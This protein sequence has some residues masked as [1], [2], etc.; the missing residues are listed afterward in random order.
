M[1]YEYRPGAAK[2]FPPWVVSA[3]G[4]AV[5]H[6]YQGTEREFRMSLVGRDGIDSLPMLLVT[7]EDEDEI[8]DD[9]EAIMR[10]SADAYA[11]FTAHNE[12][13]AADED[14]LVPD[15]LQLGG[16]A[17]SLTCEGVPFG[18]V[19]ELPAADL[20]TVSASDNGKVM[21]V[22]SGAWTVTAL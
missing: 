2:R 9:Y 1:A 12:F 13:R 3:Y 20:P 10:P 6:G 17:L 5:Q 18:T 7:T 22:V 15:G 21:K 11:Y 14:V 16:Q 4:I 19:T 8:P